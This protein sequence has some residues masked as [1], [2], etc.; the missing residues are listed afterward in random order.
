MNNIVDNNQ[1]KETLGR[2]ILA[3]GLDMVMDFERSHGSVI[4]DNLSV[5]NI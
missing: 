3:D 4:V 5:K 2:H 1:V